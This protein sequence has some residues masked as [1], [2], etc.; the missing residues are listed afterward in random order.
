MLLRGHKF[1]KGEQIVNIRGFLLITGDG[2]CILLQHYNAK[3]DAHVDDQMMISIK[4]VL[5]KDLKLFPI[6]VRMMSGRN[7]RVGKPISAR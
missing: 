7:K 4:N 1:K 2:N 5:N 6:S 3:L